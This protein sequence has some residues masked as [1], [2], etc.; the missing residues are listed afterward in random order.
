M[1]REA[2]LIDS[3]YSSFFFGRLLFLKDE[4]WTSG[5][6]LFLGFVDFLTFLLGLG[7]NSAA[8]S[9]SSCE[10]G[11][12]VIPIFLSSLLR[13]PVRDVSEAKDLELLT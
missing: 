1:V 9:N 2:L 7:N 5:E 8:M 6:C 4:P 12:F 10:D 3:G 13:W 11:L